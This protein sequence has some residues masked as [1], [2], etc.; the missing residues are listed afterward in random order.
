MQVRMK[1][2]NVYLLSN[3]ESLVYN[4]K[5]IVRVF[6]HALPESSSGLGSYDEKSLACCYAL[7]KKKT[8]KN[9]EM[10]C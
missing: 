2:K 3:S 1:K 5:S 8:T 10:I 9:K 4:R 7:G 6:L